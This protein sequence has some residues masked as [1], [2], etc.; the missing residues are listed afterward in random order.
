MDL[1]ENVNDVIVSEPLGREYWIGH[2]F[3][4]EIVDIY[5]ETGLNGWN[6][7]KAFLWTISIK[8]M[9]EAYCGTMDAVA[10]KDYIEK[11]QKAFF[12][13]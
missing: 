6:E 2:S 13:Q 3:F 12:P 10:K 4:A 9:I 8:P 1:C 11:C 5:K 7:A